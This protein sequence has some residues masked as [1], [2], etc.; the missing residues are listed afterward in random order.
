MNH[1]STSA[2]S[3]QTA[4]LAQLLRTHADGLPA[5]A[6]AVGL[7][8][9]HRYWLTRATFTDR[10][11]HPVTG[12]H[13][14]PVGAWIDWPAAVAALQH[15]DLPCSASQATILRI[16]ASLAADLPLSL[17]QV[18]GGLDAPTIAAVTTAITTAN[19]TRP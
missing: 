6:A 4:T 19:G 16:A 7:L 11:V 9:T 15:G 18:L 5:E 1:L 13:A 14:R 10:F 3:D 8:I 12:H 2:G 17:H